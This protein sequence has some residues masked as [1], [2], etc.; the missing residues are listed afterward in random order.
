MLYRKSIA[1]RMKQQIQSFLDVTADGVTRSDTVMSALAL[2]IDS[3]TML[4]IMFNT[5]TQEIIQA[6]Y[7]N[8]DLHSCKTTILPQSATS[9]LNLITLRMESLH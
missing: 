1:V 2:V 8:K 6:C 5:Y 9:K 3:L 7:S 4:C